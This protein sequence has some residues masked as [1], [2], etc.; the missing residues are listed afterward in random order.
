MLL[1]VKMLD[2]LWGMYE[3]EWTYIFYIH[4]RPK[5]GKNNEM[6]EIVFFF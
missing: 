3:K 1:L 4:F 2:F 5:F 6:S